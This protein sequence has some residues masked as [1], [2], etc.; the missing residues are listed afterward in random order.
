[1]SESPK[2]NDRVGQARR[3]AAGRLPHYCFPYAL[4]HEFL[5]RKKV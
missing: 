5:H 4:L 1:M 2:G 3:I